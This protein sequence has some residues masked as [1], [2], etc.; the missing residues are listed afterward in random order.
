M[1]KKKRRGRRRKEK[2]SSEN[3]VI[4]H[5]CPCMSQGHNHLWDSEWS[6]RGLGETAHSS[7]KETS[8][9]IQQWRH[10]ACDPLSWT[11]TQMKMGQRDARLSFFPWSMRITL[12]LQKSLTGTC[13]LNW[14]HFP[15][16]HKLVELETAPPA[17]QPNKSGSE[18][19]CGCMSLG[20]L[21]ESQH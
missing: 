18:L 13:L 10:P 17:A 3:K 5:C 4:I 9:L 19:L 8:L 1:E 16:K 15:S 11:T 6:P 2:R 7:W 12:A 14:A 21:V 20:F